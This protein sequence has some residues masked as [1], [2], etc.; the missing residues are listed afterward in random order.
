MVI[1]KADVRPALILDF[2]AFFVFPHDRLDTSLHVPVD[3]CP[4]LII[5]IHHVA[6][7]R[8]ALFE[9]LR[10]MVVDLD[11]GTGDCGYG[12]SHALSIRRSFPGTSR[13]RGRHRSATRT[14]S[15]LNR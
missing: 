12:V 8:A 5:V 9:Y 1:R 11:V 10:A 7:A 3:F 14:S 13:P 2:F 4:F 6:L 15:S